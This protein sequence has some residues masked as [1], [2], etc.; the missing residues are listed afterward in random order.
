MSNQIGEHLRQCLDLLAKIRAEYPQGN[1]DREMIHGEMDF[2]YR[3][4]KEDRE[5]LE[6]FPKE[7]REFA[8]L[9]E[10]LA[11]PHEEVKKFFQPVCVQ[12]HKF[13]P[14]ANLQF[15][16]RQ[17]KLE[18]WAAEL[19]IPPKHLNELLTRTRLAGVLNPSYEL[20][21]QYNEVINAYLKL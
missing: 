21:N 4:I 3:Q 13:S 6:T 15:H 19:Q 1:F 14:L 10:S 8:R 20:N 2:R 5:K 11:S 18:E 9:L 16:E 12:P 17:K 7:I